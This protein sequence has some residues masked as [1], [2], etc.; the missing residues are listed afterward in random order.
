MDIQSMDSSMGRAMMGLEENISS[1]RGIS[2]ERDSGLTQTWK[3][4]T[5]RSEV[6][7]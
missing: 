6:P 5:S 3:E 1:K 2:L 4:D 7:G